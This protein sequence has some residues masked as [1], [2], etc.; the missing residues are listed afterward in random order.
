MRIIQRIWFGGI[1]Y[2][3]TCY[4]APV[5]KLIS[6]AGEVGVPR[7]YKG[8][9]QSIQTDMWPCGLEPNYWMFIKK[10]SKLLLVLLYCNQCVFNLFSIINK[11]IVAIS[12]VLPVAEQPQK[13][14]GWLYVGRI[15]HQSITVIRTIIENLTGRAEQHTPHCQLIN[16]MQIPI[17]PPASSPACM[18]VPSGGEEGERR[19]NLQRS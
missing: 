14:N 5:G 12:A 9:N 19:G 15:S 3:K 11:S 7:H 2:Y 6:N 10:W 16:T 4:F 17:K 1:W 8:L 13:K 18:E